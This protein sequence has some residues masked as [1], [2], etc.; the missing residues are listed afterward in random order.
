MRPLPQMRMSSRSGESI[1][2]GVKK[3][4]A[5]LQLFG[6]GTERSPRCVIARST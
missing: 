2:C 6:T 1:A 5:P 3:T 4:G